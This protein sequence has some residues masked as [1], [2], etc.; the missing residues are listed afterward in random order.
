MLNKTHILN[1]VS[2]NLIVITYCIIIHT[3]LQKQRNKLSKII[4]NLK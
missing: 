1:T 3:T 2:L 4:K